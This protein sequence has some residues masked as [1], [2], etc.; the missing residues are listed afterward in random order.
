V[1]DTVWF[2]LVVIWYVAGVA[3]PLNAPVHDTPAGVFTPVQGVNVTTP[4]DV[5]T[6][7]VPW[8]GTITL[9]AVQFGEL[10]PLEHSLMVDVV[11]VT[12]VAPTTSFVSTFFDCAVPVT[13]D[14]V[15]GLAVGGGG[16]R[17]VGVYVELAY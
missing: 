10:W 1:E 3:V 13:P 6:V 12:P 15:S 11:N 4:V 7:Y 5:F 14:V 16:G 17:T 8:P 2:V 9:D